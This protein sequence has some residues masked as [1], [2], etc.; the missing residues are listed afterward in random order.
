MNRTKQSSSLAMLILAAAAWTGCSTGLGTPTGTGGGANGGS[1]ATGG[2]GGGT[3]GSGNAGG[4][5]VTPQP[6]PGT[7]T[8]RGLVARYF[9]DEAASGQT[10]T[11]VVD[12]AP[13]PVDLTLVYV[14]DVDG[15]HLGY[16]EDANGNRGL[17][18]DEASRDDRASVA[19]DGTKLHTMIDG[20]TT[21]TFEVVAEV[22]DTNSSS[23]RLSHF[24]FDQDHTL[25]FE[26]HVLTRLTGSVNDDTT[27]RVALYHPDVGRGVF[28]MVVDTAAS[29]PAERTIIYVNGGAYPNLEGD[30]PVEGA[31]LDLMMDRHY[32]IG[33][34]EVGERS[35]QG[36]IYYSALYNVALTPIEVAQNAALL[37]ID[38]DAPST[39]TP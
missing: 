6:H 4:G 36:A 29:G 33:N 7:L 32:V 38:D 1:G 10:V 9:L 16:T 11:T 5:T 35:I 24:G 2:Q 30:A 8:D 17:A 31:P 18:F 14:N 25:S 15:E 28:H 20:G 37:L 26:T 23:S 13:N 12:A 21:I 19:I 39:P 3:G 34:R 22:L 27:G